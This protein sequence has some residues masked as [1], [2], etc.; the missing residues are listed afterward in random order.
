MLLWSSCAGWVELVPACSGSARLIASLRSQL[1]FQ[2]CSLILWRHIFPQM[3]FTK[4]DPLL[5]HG[6]LSGELLWR[7]PRP[8]F[9]WDFSQDFMFLKKYLN[10]VLQDAEYSP[11]F[12]LCNQIFVFLPLSKSIFLGN[13]EHH[14]F[15]TE[16]GFSCCLCILW[17][18]GTLPLQ[19]KKSEPFPPHWAMRKV[20]FKVTN[21]NTSRLKKRKDVFTMFWAL[22]KASCLE[23][24]WL[25]PPYLLLVG[26]S[27]WK[28]TNWAVFK[29]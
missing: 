27:W 12:L 15:K 16:G 25:S 1:C 21:A 6:E 17:F 8:A 10:N 26:V 19:E 9:P 18:V 14:V 23:E 2:K 22:C 5:L 28:L 24:M 3:H 13:H 29:R 7:F 11:L 4:Y 20:S